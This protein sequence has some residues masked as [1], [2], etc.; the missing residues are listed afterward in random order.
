[1]TINL[2]IKNPKVS[3]PI[4]PNRNQ[5][6]TLVK[7]KKMRTHRKH[8]EGPRNHDWLETSRLL[9]ILR[10]ATVAG[11]AYEIHSNVPNKIF[12]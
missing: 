5:V 6:N 2:K 3:K 11:A 1:M 7:M 9:K 8:L 4:K 10:V 12:R